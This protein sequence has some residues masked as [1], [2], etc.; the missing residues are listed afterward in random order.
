MS[1]IFLNCNPSHQK[2]HGHLHRA[3]SV[4]SCRLDSNSPSIR[5]CLVQTPPIWLRLPNRLTRSLCTS[6]P[7]ALGFRRPAIVRP[8]IVPLST[9]LSSLS[10]SGLKS[11]ASSGVFVQLRLLCYLELPCTILAPL[12][13]LVRSFSLCLPKEV[14]CSVLTPLSCARSR[15]V[16]PSFLR[17]VSAPL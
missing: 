4:S 16:P 3:Y 13:G 8:A 6:P 2:G 12:R 7:T 14:G 17:S 10:V 15:S 9:E 5:Q 1:W 11:C